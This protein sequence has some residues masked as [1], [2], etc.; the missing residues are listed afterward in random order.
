MVIAA[1][2]ACGGRA[3]PPPLAAYDAAAHRADVEAWRAWRHGELVK[4][5]GWLSLSGLYWLTPGTYRLGAAPDSDLVYAREGVPAWLGTLEVTP[6]SVDFAPAPDV[7]IVVGDG[8]AAARVFDEA[9]REAG[10]EP[11]IMS[12]GDLQWYVIVREDH[13]ALRL[14]DAASPRVVEFEGMDYFELAPEWRFDATF[15]VYDP[16]KTIT[17]PNVFGTLGDEE[18]PGAVVFERD[19]ETYRLDMWRDSDDPDNFFT[20]FGDLTNAGLTYGA[21]RFLWV[22]APDAWGRTVVDFN[23]SYNPPCAFSAFATCPL[24]PAQNR[25]SLPVE[26]GEMAFGA[27]VDLPKGPPE[28]L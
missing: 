7:G 8:T 22:D 10:I 18:S 26:A 27:K 4:P 3:E 15:E 21:G 24:P 28:G 17:I 19:G 1:T 16:P 11:P 14:K 6:T 20:A 25:L 5:D 12:W 2:A 23:R 13:F 9:W